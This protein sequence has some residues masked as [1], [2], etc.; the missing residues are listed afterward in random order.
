MDEG[1]A[2]K[3]SS[4]RHGRQGVSMEE[5]DKEMERK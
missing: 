2:A 4:S 3:W 1:V 5:N